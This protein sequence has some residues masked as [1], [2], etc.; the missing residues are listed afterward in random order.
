[1]LLGLLAHVSR[2]MEVG[3]VG[4]GDCSPKSIPRQEGKG[5]ESV[6]WEVECISSHCPN[7]YLQGIMIV[8]CLYRGQIQNYEHWKFRYQSVSARQGHRY[9]TLDKGMWICHLEGISKAEWDQGNANYIEVKQDIKTA[10]G[11]DCRKYPLIVA[12]SSIG[13]DQHETSFSRRF[14]VTFFTAWIKF[15]LELQEKEAV[16]KE[17]TITKPWGRNVDWFQRHQLFPLHKE[18][19]TGRSYAFT[20]RST[21]VKGMAGSAPRLTYWTVASEYLSFRLYRSILGGEAERLLC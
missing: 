12:N 3:F 13:R 11:G 15:T 19:P 2:G 9:P 10:G 16:E 4:S 1:M 7:L 5:R 14:H 20:Y 8:Q 21:A 18:H 6:I 17:E